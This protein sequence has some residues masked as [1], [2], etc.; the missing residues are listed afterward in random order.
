MALV[1]THLPAMSGESIG[2]AR[3]RETGAENVSEIW[4]FGATFWAPGAG[5]VVFR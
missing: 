4:V 3:R 5:V 2:D 1:C